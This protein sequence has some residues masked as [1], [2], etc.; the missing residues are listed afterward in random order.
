ME[1]EFVANA[2]KVPR[3]YRVR[4]RFCVMEF[5]RYVFERCRGAIGRDLP[6]KCQSFA[7]SVLCAVC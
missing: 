6:L 7:L 2:R 1:K 3:V 5:Q 4:D